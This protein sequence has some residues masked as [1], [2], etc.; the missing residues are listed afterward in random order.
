MPSRLTEQSI[1]NTF[2][3]PTDGSLLRLGSALPLHSVSFP[4][5]LQDFSADFV[6][7]APGLL[8]NANCI[9]H[10]LN[11]IAVFLGHSLARVRELNPFG[12]QRFALPRHFEPIRRRT[13]RLARTFLWR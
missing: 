8:V 4:F 12:T 11:A 5:F 9:F 6:V 3:S 10:V 7:D 1:R 2:V 13:L